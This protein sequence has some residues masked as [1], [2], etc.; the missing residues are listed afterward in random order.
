MPNMKKA[1][2][3]IQGNVKTS[4]L[5]RLT[6]ADLPNNMYGGGSRISGITAPRT[7]KYVPVPKGTEVRP[8]K[9]GKLNRFG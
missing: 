4:T 2:N 7:V 3:K 8:P 5:G 9:R 6:K 1:Y